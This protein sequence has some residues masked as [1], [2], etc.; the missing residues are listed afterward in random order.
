MDSENRKKYTIDEIRRKDKFNGYYKED[1]KLIGFWRTVDFIKQGQKF[2]YKVRK[3]KKEPLL[4]RITVNPGDNS[5][6]IYLKDK[7]LILSKYTKNYILNI[8]APDTLCNYKY[9]KISGKDYILP[10]IF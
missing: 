4:Q 7:S 5:V 9:Q 2:N 10:L 3:S 6:L 8:A 1:Y